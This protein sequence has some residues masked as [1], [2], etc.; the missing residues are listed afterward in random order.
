MHWVR[1]TLSTLWAIMTSRWY[2][3]IVAAAALIIT[4][5]YFIL[6]LLISLPPPW[7]ALTFF[8]IIGGWGVASGY[9]DW[10]IFKSKEEK[11]IKS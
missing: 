4:A 9:K 6:M 7:N 10:V 8:L 5:P 3:F 2:W 11:K 1:E